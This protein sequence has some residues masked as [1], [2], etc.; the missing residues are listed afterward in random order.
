MDFFHLCV[1]NRRKRSVD[2][3][4]HCGHCEKGGNSKSD[5]GRNRS[6]VKPKRDPGDDDKHT[7]GH[8]DGEEVVGELPFEHQGHFKA[9][10]LARVCD[11]VAIGGLKLLQ[12]EP[13]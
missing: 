11:G 5:S 3:S 12:L 2:P 8:V 1:S 10:V 7:G 4:G 13:R 9:A 6:T